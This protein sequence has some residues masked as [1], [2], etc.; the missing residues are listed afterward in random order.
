MLMTKRYWRPICSSWR[1]WFFGLLG[2][3]AFFW[4]L[5]WPFWANVLLALVITA[6]GLSEEEWNAKC[7]HD[8]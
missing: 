3:S 8:N 1:E 4:P 6:L 7:R 2:L 5:G